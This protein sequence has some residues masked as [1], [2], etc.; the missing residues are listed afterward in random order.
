MRL[1]SRRGVP[2]WPM[3]VGGPLG[4]ASSSAPAREEAEGG[5]GGRD[6]RRRRRRKQG[7]GGGGGGGGRGRREG[8]GRPAAE[9][10]RRQRRRRWERAEAGASGR[11]KGE[12][13][14]ER[15]GDKVGCWAA[16]I[17]LFFNSR[18]NCPRFFFF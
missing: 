6:E 13:E 12:R 15:G 11:S 3:G 17:G 10:R 14:K 18:L 5:E 4:G 7:T 2:A 1:G 16:L 9:A 8:G